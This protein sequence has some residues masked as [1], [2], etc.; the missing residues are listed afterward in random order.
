MPRRSWH[1]LIRFPTYSAGVKHRGDDDRLFNRLQLAFVGRRRVVDRLTVPSE[2]TALYSTV[3]AVVIRSRLYSRSRRSCT[4]SMQK[5]QEAE[6]KPKPKASWSRFPGERCVVEVQLFQRFPQ[7][8]YRALSVGKMPAKTI[9]LTTLKPA[10]ARQQVDR[11]AS[12]CRRS[13]CRRRS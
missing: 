1:R 2:A 6:R 9:G 12:P 7:L 5:A 11:R 10:A 3:G 4:I 8:V 13:W